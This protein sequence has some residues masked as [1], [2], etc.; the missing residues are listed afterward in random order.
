M[1]KDNMK[2]VNPKMDIMQEGSTAVAT[3]QER[4]PAKMPQVKT[5]PTGKKAASKATPGMG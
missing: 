1:A 2:L 3:Q 5:M 4:A